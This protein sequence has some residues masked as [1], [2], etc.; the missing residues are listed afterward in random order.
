VEE[1]VFKT[2]VNWRGVLDKYWV[3][4]D[5]LYQHIGFR[6]FFK[7]S[8]PYLYQLQNEMRVHT[9][10]P[11][12]QAHLTA[13]IMNILVGVDSKT[14]Y[15]ILTYVPFVVIILYDE[16]TYAQLIDNY[17]TAPTCFNTIVSSSGIS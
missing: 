9:S 17:S 7:G 15:F 16:P 8:V 4:F 12:T 14:N 1:T 11:H 3:S 2:Q 6:A 10:S 13:D 5:W